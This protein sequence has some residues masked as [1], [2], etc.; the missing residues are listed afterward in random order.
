MC[1]SSSPIQLQTIPKEYFM[2]LMRLVHFSTLESM[3]CQ[4]VLRNGPPQLYWNGDRTAFPK[5]LA[6]LVQMF[7]DKAASSLKGSTL[8]ASQ[9][10]VVLHNFGDAYKR[11][12]IQS[13]LTFVAF[14]PLE[15]A[16]EQKGCNDK[17][18][19]IKESSYQ[20]SSFAVV[21]KPDSIP[22]TSSIGS[23]KLKMRVLHKV[24]S[25]ILSDIR[26]I[27]LEGFRE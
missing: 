27:C 8:V 4:K 12:L 22:V 7:S 3:V 17:L 24:L 5:S 10:Y 16:A 2:H 20:H 13:A 14:L 21:V 19:E 15:S 18:A 6:G 11:W 9:V 26:E 1:A 25:V 23:K